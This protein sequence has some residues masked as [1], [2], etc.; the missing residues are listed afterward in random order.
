MSNQKDNI[1]FE[2]II[3]DLQRVA[4]DET[5]SQFIKDFPAAGSIFSIGRA[6]GRIDIVKK[7]VDIIQEE[8]KEQTVFLSADDFFLKYTKEKNNND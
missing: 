5:I 3:S 6:V 1:D 4:F 8:M 2:K 7:L